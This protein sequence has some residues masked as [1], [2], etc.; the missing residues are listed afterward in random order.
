M[1]TELREDV[2]WLDLS[3]VNAY[4]VDDGGTVTLVDAG[5][6]WDADAVL[7]GVVEAGYALADLDRVLVTHYDLDHVGGLS[8]LGGLDV[9]VYAGAGD[10]PL[11][12]GTAS[13]DLSSRKGLLQL[14]G[15][16]LVGTPPDDVRSLA[17]GDEVG[18]FTVYETPGHTPGHVAYVSESLGV[19]FVGDLV[20]EANGE[21]EASPW[22]L[23]DDTEAVERS[24]RTLADRMPD[25]T[26]LVPGHGVPFN[27]GGTDRLDDLATQLWAPPVRT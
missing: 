22:L 9:T 21:L 18:S 16:P 8:R 23:S 15:S 6:V 10:A 27:E 12:A 19:A 13:P 1:P 4:V 3:G 24:I 25:V 14:L 2:W 11:V 17:D 20:R 7:D 26:V 5:P